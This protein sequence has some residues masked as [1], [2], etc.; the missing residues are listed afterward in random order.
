MGILAR[1]TEW[2]VAGQVGMVGDEQKMR[3]PCLKPAVVNAD[4]TKSWPCGADRS[5][6]FKKNQKYGF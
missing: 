5:N 1:G 4:K 2:K 3:M 6:F